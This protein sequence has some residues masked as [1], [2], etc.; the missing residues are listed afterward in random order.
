MAQ[1]QFFPITSSNLDSAAFDR[2]WNELVV[3]F[4]NGTAYKYQDVTQ[5]LWADFKKLFDGKSGSAG[6][7]FAKQIRFLTNERI[8]DWQ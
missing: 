1:T 5:S 2:D 7:F 3:R 8:E 4:K 6:S